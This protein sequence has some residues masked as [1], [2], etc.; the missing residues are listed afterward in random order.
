MDRPTINDP[1][2]ELYYTSAKAARVDCAL[3]GVA[4]KRV[5]S[6]DRGP[7]RQGYSQTTGHWHREWVSRLELS[8]LNPGQTLE[9]HGHKIERLSARKWR[10]DDR[11]LR[12]MEDVVGFSRADIPITHKIVVREKL[13]RPFIGQLQAVDDETYWYERRTQ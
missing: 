12:K 5:I 1:M 10:L 6:L 8:E 4:A 7:Y 2:L 9:F 3:M 11:E 13:A